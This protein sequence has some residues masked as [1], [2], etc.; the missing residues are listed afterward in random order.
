MQKI[1]QVTAGGMGI[2]SQQK[3]LT[4]NFFF[5]THRP[6]PFIVNHS[7]FYKLT[8]VL[9][10]YFFKHDMTTALISVSFYVIPKR[11]SLVLKYDGEREATGEDER[12][13]EKK[14]S[15]TRLWE[16]QKCNVV[17]K[18]EIPMFRVGPF[19]FWYCFK[20]FI[21]SHVNFII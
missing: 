2:R 17:I 10:Y 20:G 15:L 13:K 14:N 21:I 1:F 9:K 16:R 3:W 18:T 8:A 12:G 4:I 5:Y 7:Q 19:I 11:N 6:I